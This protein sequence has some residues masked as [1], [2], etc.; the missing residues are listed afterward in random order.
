MGGDD[1]LMY[2]TCVSSALV[3]DVPEFY[4]PNLFLITKPK[5]FQFTLMMETE[6]PS[7][8]V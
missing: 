3:P 1:D 6:A 2:A 8:R 4:P 5:A 7:E